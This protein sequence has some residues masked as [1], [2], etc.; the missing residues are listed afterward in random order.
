MLDKYSEPRRDA[1]TLAARREALID[2]LGWL[3]DEAAAL[4][5]LLDALPAWAVEQAPMPTDLSAKQTFAALAALDR[6]VYPDWIARLQAEDAPDLESP[7]LEAE[8]NANDRDLGD[9]LSDLRAAR[10][11]LR[12]TVEAVPAEAWARRATLD[13]DA[14]DLY[15]IAL[16]IVQRD[17]EHLKELAY[18]LHDADLRTP[19]G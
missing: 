8:E 16:A 4:A 7:P 15:G 18:R 1:A 5:P 19:K 2:Q 14:T 17:A 11:A 6:D 3:E 10:E 9:L 12:G 13:G